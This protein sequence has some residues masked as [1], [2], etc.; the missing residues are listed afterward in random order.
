MVSTHEGE[1]QVFPRVV[2]DD[3]KR[4]FNRLRAADV[5]LNAALHAKSLFAVSGN[6]RCDFNLLSVQILARELRKALELPFQ[7]VVQSRILITEAGRRIPHL[8]V[9]VR[10]T[11]F[12]IQITPFATYED[13]GWFHVVDRVPKG[14][15]LALEV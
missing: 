3:L 10:G 6:P 5:E 11:V 8:Q 9:E 2:A 13:L 7:R 14:A 15:I 12:V 4:I 1:Y